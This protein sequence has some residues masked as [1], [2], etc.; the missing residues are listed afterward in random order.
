MMGATVPTWIDSPNHHEWLVSQTD[1]LLLF[2]RRASADHEHGGFWW[3][4]AHGEPMRNRGKQ[5]WIAARH[6]YCF[7]VGT[8]MGR[9]GYRPLVESGIDFLRSGALRDLEH[10]GWFWAVDAAGEPTDGS[11]QA[12]GHAFVVIAACAAVSVGLDAQ[13]V[14]D[15]ALRVLDERFWNAD[16]QMFADTWNRSFTVLD[17]YRG[18]NANMHLVEAMMLAADVTG[19]AEYLTRAVAIAERLIHVVTAANDGR[20]PEHFAPGWVFA[21]EYNADDRDNLF[22]PY[23]SIIGHWL[24]WARL[25]TQL[26]AA[27]G[28]EHAWMIP[29]ARSLFDRAVAEGWNPDSAGFA[30]STDWSGNVINNDRYHWVIAEALGAAVALQRVTADPMY[31]TWYQRFWEYAAAH[32][33]DPKDGSWTH[34]LDGSNRPTF[35][36]WDGKPD[37]Y[38]ALQATL[39]ARVPGHRSLIVELAG[40]RRAT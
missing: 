24:E 13:D 3:L 10:G 16:D 31:D 9:P 7:A 38:H 22:R 27:T 2:H 29:A 11:K 21:P 6:T 30:Y 19:N 28:R 1:A 5:L 35:S 36:A 8:A 40:R 18:Q 4:D 37:L 12:Y 32:H 39:F 23:G 26:H 15:D 17:D 25:L 33:I 14:L 34:Q 20:L